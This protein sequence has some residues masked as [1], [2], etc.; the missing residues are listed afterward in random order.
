MTSQTL[1]AFGVPPLLGR[2]IGLEDE[3]AGAPRVVMLAYGY[4][5]DRFGGDPD[6]VGRNIEVGTV[7][8]QIVGVMPRGFKF[9]DVAPQ[10]IV[11]LTVNRANLIPPPFCC[12]G[13]ARLH[14]GV[15]LEQASADIERMLPIW[16]E[17]FPFP[18]VPPRSRH[19]RSI[20]TVGA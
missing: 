3:S 8:S 10:L 4:W 6:I 16:V 17:R 1:E 18:P 7:S 2:W 11:A 9:G 14:G 5:Q 12:N 20:S 15:T 19:A 13:I